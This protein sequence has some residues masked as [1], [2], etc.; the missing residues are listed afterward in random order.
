MANLWSPLDL[1]YAETA[2]EPVILTS[3]PKTHP[4]ML[5]PEVERYENDAEMLLHSPGDDDITRDAV[6]DIASRTCETKRA[7]SSSP[8]E[9]G[10]ESRQRP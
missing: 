5:R 2:T 4:L 7:R 3:S 10:N 6:G 9:E 1:T 8:L